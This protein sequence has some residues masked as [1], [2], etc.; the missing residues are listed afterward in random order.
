M[1]NV[2]SHATLSQTE[3]F[4]QLS[5]IVSLLNDECAGH[6]CVTFATAD[7][8]VR[9]RRRCHGK[10]QRFPRLKQDTGRFHRYG[11]RFACRIHEN[12]TVKFVHFPPGVVDRKDQRRR[13][14]DCYE[15]R[16]KAKVFGDERDRL[17]SFASYHSRGN[18]KEDKER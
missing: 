1:G 16:G 5:R 7:V 8:E 9:S 10:L 14:T 4:S 12:S 17:V 15:L 2:N 13:R 3:R 6:I 11:R 18:E